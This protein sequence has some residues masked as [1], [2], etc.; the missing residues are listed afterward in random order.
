MH[1]A[2][3]NPLCKT[4][5]WFT[6]LYGILFEVTIIIFSQAIVIFPLIAENKDH[7]Y[8]KLVKWG[9]CMLEQ[10]PMITD[11]QRYSSGND[12]REFIISG[13]LIWSKYRYA[14]NNDET[15]SE[16]LI[17]ML[18]IGHWFKMHMTSM[19]VVCCVACC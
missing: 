11:M 7:Y 13:S 1:D 4:N 2:F 3:I 15:Q 19:H 16:L 18:A 9:R 10:K 17:T 5:T 12:S 6:G 14:A 8:C